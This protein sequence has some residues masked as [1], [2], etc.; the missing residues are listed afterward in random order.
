VVFIVAL[1]WWFLA[2]EAKQ[3]PTTKNA[4]ITEVFVNLIKLHKVQVILIMGL[5]VFA[6]S[7]GLHSW[8]PRLLETGGFSP[9]V[10]G[11]SSS[12]P[13]AVGIPAILV[14][15]HITPPQLRECV[16]A[17]FALLAA[18]AIFAIVATSGVLF[19]AGLVLFG[20]TASSFMPLLLLVLMDSPELDSRYMGAAGGLFF[21]VAEI[22]GFSGPLIIG[23][24]ADTTGNFTAVAIFFAF[25]LL[26]VFFLALLF[27]WLKMHSNPRTV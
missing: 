19:F 20:I 22:G 12:I 10:A 24:L 3:S 26:A 11:Y 15:P 2:K 27:T 23:I 9:T 6:T 17:F 25:V 16:I 14:I 18:A 13:L 8:L 21:C 5:L 1:L 7:H 4:G